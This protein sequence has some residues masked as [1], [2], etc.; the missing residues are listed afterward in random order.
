MR[1]GLRGLSCEMLGFV[2]FGV[3]IRSRLF[4]SGFWWLDV[5]EVLLCG[6]DVYKTWKT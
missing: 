6:N 1:G 4:E 3:C 2:G 5:L